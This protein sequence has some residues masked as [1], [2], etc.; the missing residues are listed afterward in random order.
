M[1]N[2]NT[3]LIDFTH[4]LFN[5]FVKHNIVLDY[6]L[7]DFKIKLKYNELIQKGMRSKDARFQ[8]ADE[9]FLSEK[10]IQKIIY[11]KVKFHPLPK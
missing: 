11:S 4:E 10:T 6:H 1:E 5:L 7:R 8:V 3:E 9:F 2:F